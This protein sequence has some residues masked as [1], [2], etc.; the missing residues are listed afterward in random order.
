MR[1]KLQRASGIAM[2]AT[3][4]T[5]LFGAAGTGAWAEENIPVLIP[6]KIQPQFVSEP[7]VQSIPAAE[8]QDTPAQ[9]D[10]AEDA[11]QRY[12]T[13]A[14]F[15][16]AQPHDDELDRQ[17]HCLA[18]AIYFEARGESL[19]GQLAVGRVIVQRTN[20]GRFPDSYCGVVFQR[21]Q[22]SFVRGSSMPTIRQSSSAWQR[23]VKL[24]KIADE[25]SWESPAEG[26]LFFH[27]A[28]V[29]PGWRLT[30]LARVD[31]HVFYR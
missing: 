30:R 21:A 24:A 25:G 1:I 10:D 22:F 5:A 16:D 26:A 13:L 3:M 15:V 12:E 11:S 31:N 19:A 17:M 2:A 29:T 4:L 18:S 20:S 6:E 7:I 28:R 9:E 23:A 27:A 14:A 8:A